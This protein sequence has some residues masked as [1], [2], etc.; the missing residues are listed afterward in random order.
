MASIGC[1]K[2]LE[3]GSLVQVLA[4]WDMGSVELHAVFPGGKAGKP[5]AKSFAAFLAAEFAHGPIA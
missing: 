3:E 5:S 1:R 4:D 2:E